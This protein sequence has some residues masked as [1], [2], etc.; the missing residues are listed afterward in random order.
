MS[1]KME[2]FGGYI[3][4]KGKSGAE[5]TTVEERSASWHFYDSI[6]FMR[7]HIQS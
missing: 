6:S 5:G 7:P 1:E 2:G 4:E 3:P